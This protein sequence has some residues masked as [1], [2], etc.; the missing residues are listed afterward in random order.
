MRRRSDDVRSV[1][2][3]QSTRVSKPLT[4]R[5]VAP[6]C[7][8]RHSV[9]RRR[10]RRQVAAP[11]V[12]VHRHGHHRSVGH[13]PGDHQPASPAATHQRAPSCST[14][15]S[16]QAVST[17]M[18]RTCGLSLSN[19][20]SKFVGLIFSLSVSAMFISNYKRNIK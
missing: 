8:C 19:H 7:Q 17:P 1:T 14:R 18:N 3:R 12:K 20:S 13:S 10:R 5:H 15:T 9:R 16:G 4:R 6:V 11:A 2:K